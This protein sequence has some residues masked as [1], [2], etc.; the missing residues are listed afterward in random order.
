MSARYHRAKLAGFNSFAEM[1]LGSSMIETPERVHL[2]LDAAAKSL[3]GKARL[4]MD[5]FLKVKKFM[6]DNLSSEIQPWDVTNLSNGVVRFSYTQLSPEHIMEYFTIQNVLDGMKYVCSSL[7][8]VN[9]VE[10]ELKEKETWVASTKFAGIFKYK[11]VHESG[12][13]LGYDC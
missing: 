6:P 5:A 11:F 10:E 13:N 12:A 1:T 4:E 2:F 3:E 8:G 7:F 9:M